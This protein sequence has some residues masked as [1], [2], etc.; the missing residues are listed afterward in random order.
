M[1]STTDTT[2]PA[3]RDGAPPAPR[4]EGRGR[5]PIHADDE[6]LL[7]A[8]Q[9]FAAQGYAATSI[10]ALNAEL[11]LSHATIGQRFG[12]KAELFRAAIDHGFDAFLGQIE[13]ERHRLLAGVA[14]P[15]DL[16]D[17]AAL[18]E[19]F[20]VVA[21]RWPELGRLMNQEGL[22]P[23]DRLAYIV[24]RVI[25]P[26]FLPAAAVLQR[27][28]AAGRIRPITARALF[29]LVAHGAEAPFTL[30]AL[31][32]VFDA[33]DGPLDAEAHAREMAALIVRGMV[34]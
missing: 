23:S 11:G 25:T 2:A 26:A 13:H 21:A 32:E 9:A 6:L 22:A 27:L 8:L 29:F 5:P 31:S 15:D 7:A 16:D 18:I 30:T 12:T 10:R 14:D 20:L 4:G 34:A 24:E 28:A 17:L 33:I 3:R 1:A 19:A